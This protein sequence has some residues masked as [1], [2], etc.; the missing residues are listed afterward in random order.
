[1]GHK[2]GD[3]WKEGRAWKIQMPDLIRTTKT[4]KEALHWAE[5]VHSP[6]CWECVGVGSLYN[7]C[8][9]CDGSGNLTDRLRSEYHQLLAKLPSERTIS[10][11]NLRLVSTAIKFCT[12]DIAVIHPIISGIKETELN[13]Y[14]VVL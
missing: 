3:I 6:L 1:M 10:G 5:S 8:D 9:L 12:G 7:G 13:E 14:Q 2:L 11:K 4:K